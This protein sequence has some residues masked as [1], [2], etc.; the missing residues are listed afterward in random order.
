MKI[1]VKDIKGLKKL[2]IHK[3]L[4]QASMG[5]E[6]GIAKSYACQIV[7]GTRNP[8]PALAKKISETLEVE[9]DE[10]FFIKNGSKSENISVQINI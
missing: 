10:I 5:K 1:V 9:F 7:N 3:G 6:V 8:S 4:S 2:L